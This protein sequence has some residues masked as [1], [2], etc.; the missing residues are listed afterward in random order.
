MKKVSELQQKLLYAVGK[1][2]DYH[3]Y[4]MRLSELEE[5]YDETL[6]IYDLTVWEGN[7]GETIRSKAVTMLR[8][9]AELFEDLCF[10]ARH[11][12][13]SVMEEIRSLE[14]VD[15]LEILGFTLP[16][17]FSIKSDLEDALMEW[18]GYEYSQ[19]KALSSF[20]EYLERELELREKYPLLRK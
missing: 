20:L 18:E 17:H 6:E 8:L 15:Q 13:C 4:S 14:E 12:L 1:Y 3:D 2:S 9:T 5:N 10:N 11:E 16:S 19:E 7:T